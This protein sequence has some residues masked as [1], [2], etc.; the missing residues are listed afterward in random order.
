MREALLIEAFALLTRV[1]GGGGGDRDATALYQEAPG[2]HPDPIAV[3]AAWWRPIRR[4][5]RCYPPPVRVNTR[6]QRLPS[7]LGWCSSTSMISSTSVS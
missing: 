4:A 2:F 3:V 7:F 1:S 5:V 6:C